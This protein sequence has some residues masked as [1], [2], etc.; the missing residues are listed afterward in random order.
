[1]CKKASHVLHHQN[2]RTH[3]IYELVKLDNQLTARIIE[4]FAF[5]CLTECLARNAAHQN[6]DIA[7]VLCQIKSFHVLVLH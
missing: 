1:M 3:L 7:V 6:V 5:P 4:A 2:L